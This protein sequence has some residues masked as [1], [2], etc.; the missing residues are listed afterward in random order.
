MPIQH[1][2]ILRYLILLT[3]IHTRQNS[4]SF[5]GE[6]LQTSV[7]NKTLYSIFFEIGLCFHSLKICM[8]S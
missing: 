6:F 4:T 3:N 7:T 8:F 2:E 5:Q 1:E